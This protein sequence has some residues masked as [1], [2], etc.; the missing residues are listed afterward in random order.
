MKFS[1]EIII[2]NKKIS[3]EENVFIIAEAGIN[4]NGNFDIAKKLIFEAKKSGCDA[5]K[6]QSFLPNSRVSK[7]VKSERYVEK[8]INTEESI[9]ELFE[10]V[11]LSFSDQK[12][13]FEYAKKIKILMFSTA[14]DFESADFLEKLGVDVYKIASMDLTNIPLVEHIAKKMKPVILSTGMSKLHEID[15]TV[16]AFK[17]TGNSNLIIL[18]C[19]SSYPS[20]YEEINLKFM[21]SLSNIY[22]SPIGYSDHSG[23]L[24]IDE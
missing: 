24:S 21:D 13:L 2:N 16:E 10:K 22:P 9:S 23:E 12:K 20:N 15:E 19:N 5:I 14:F 6:F 7:K 1:R 4:H 17:N 3:E 8:V 11:T 18:H